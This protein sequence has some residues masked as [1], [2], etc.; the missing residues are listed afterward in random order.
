MYNLI[1][2]LFVLG[3]FYF[4]YSF[5][6]AL[7]NDRNRKIWL[8][9]S[10]TAVFLFLAGLVGIDLYTNLNDL[11]ADEF[12]HYINLLYRFVFI[13]AATVTLVL[14]KMIPR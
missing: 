14:S 12:K 6:T 2:F 3:L 10:A 5:I 8:Y 13:A 4:I 1:T 11:A 9:G 7:K